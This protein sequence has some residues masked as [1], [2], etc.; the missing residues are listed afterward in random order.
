MSKHILTILLLNI[1]AFCIFSIFSEY[2]SVADKIASVDSAMAMS[3][4]S[5]VQLTLSSEEL[6]GNDWR[7]NLVTS[8][9]DEVSTGEV[10]G[11]TIQG[12]SDFRGVFVPYYNGSSWVTSEL[13]NLSSGLDPDDNTFSVDNNIESPEDVYNFLYNEGGHFSAFYSNVGKKLTTST[14]EKVTSAESYATDIF[15]LT[16]VS[17]RV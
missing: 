15:D 2:F 8:R 4:D 13:Y 7:S 11:D 9:V 10:S 1:T 12:T 3:I 6:F 16:K 14:Y 5:A 17:R